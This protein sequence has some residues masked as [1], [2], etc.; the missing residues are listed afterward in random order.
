ML[1]FPASWTV[2]NKVLLFISHPVYSILLQQP[3]QMEKVP[4]SATVKVRL[5]ISTSSAFLIWM[6]MD[7]KGRGY[8]KER[9]AT[10]KGSVC[11]LS[12][13]DS[14]APHEC[15]KCSTS[16]VIKI[17]PDSPRPWPHLAKSWKWKKNPECPSIFSSGSHEQ[18]SQY[19]GPMNVWMVI[20]W[21]HH[22]HQRNRCGSKEDIC[23]LC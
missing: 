23:K 20:W 14:E 18:K 22:W 19:G 8:T 4:I 12:G 5:S 3:G 11:S 1:D 10:Q 13:K 17:S 9:T 21:V 2:R 16:R 7:F 6:W 15:W